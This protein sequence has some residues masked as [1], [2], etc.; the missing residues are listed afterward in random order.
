MGCCAVDTK[1]RQFAMYNVKV[2]ALHLMLTAQCATWT[3]AAAASVATQHLLSPE[4]DNHV[5]WI[6]WIPANRPSRDKEKIF[7]LTEEKILL[8]PPNQTLTST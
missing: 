6:P 1:K 8:L 4:L 3:R 7:L 2:R 5:H